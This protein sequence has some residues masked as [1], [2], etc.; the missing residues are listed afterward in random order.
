MRIT[1]RELVDRGERN[2]DADRR[3]FGEDDLGFAEGEFDGHLTLVGPG[4]HI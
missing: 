4:G 2:P 3:L 1:R